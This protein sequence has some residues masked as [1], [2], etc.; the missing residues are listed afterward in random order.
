M[1]APHPLLPSFPPAG[2][3][4]AAMFRRG[5]A[6]GGWTLPAT[7][8]VKPPP[9]A[10]AAA[11]VADGALWVHGGTGGQGAGSPLRRGVEELRD[12][13]RVAIRVA[14]RVKDGV[15]ERSSESRTARSRQGQ[16]RCRPGA[17]DVVRSG[18]SH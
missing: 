11:A 1:H 13:I 14:I 15:E 17:G 5:P 16:R 7:G 12:T 8:G 2:R 4:T 9:R 3:P 10:Y 18:S 6:D